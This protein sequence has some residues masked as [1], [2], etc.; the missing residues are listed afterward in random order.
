MH[1][2]H[3][4][5]TG[6]QSLNPLCADSRKFVALPGQIADRALTVLKYGF[7]ALGFLLAFILFFHPAEN[8]DFFWHF[9]AG[10]Y[11]VRNLAFPRSDFLSWSRA[12]TPWVD[13]EWLSQVL[14][15]F[16]YS[17][18]GLWLLY[19]LKVLVLSPAVGEVP[20]KPF[21]SEVEV[22]RC[23]E[24]VRKQLYEIGAKILTRR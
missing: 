18:G 5:R 19:A 20:G 4:E 10:K 17:A 15:Y 8:P 22:R 6:T 2:V 13:F 14:Y 16:T 11:I 9:S 3:Q 1:L 12:G 24:L 7:L 23:N 21:E